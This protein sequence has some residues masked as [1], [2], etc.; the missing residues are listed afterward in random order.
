MNLW[1]WVCLRF[2]LFNWENLVHYNIS[3]TGMLCSAQSKQPVYQPCLSQVDF[4]YMHIDI[5][6]FVYITQKVYLFCYWF[7]FY[8][9]RYVVELVS[10]F[11][12]SVI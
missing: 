3:R 5:I 8:R 4:V 10:S 11:G 1:L 6:Y 2:G 12:S 7:M 9:E